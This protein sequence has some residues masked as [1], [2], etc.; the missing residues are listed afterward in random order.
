M[1]AL[2]VTAGDSVI[3]RCS[4]KERFLPTPSSDFPAV[5]Y[6]NDVFIGKEPTG[7][8]TLG[9]VSESDTGLYRCEHP[10]QG[11]SPASW[12]TVRGN[13]MNLMQTT[14]EVLHVSCLTLVVSITAGPPT[15]S[16]PP[17]I[18]IS[19]PRLVCTVLL[20]VLY[21]V[22]FILCVYVHCRRTKGKRGSQDLP[23][24]ENILTLARNKSMMASCTRGP[25]SHYCGVD[26]CKREV[27]KSNK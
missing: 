3:L 25:R 13:V 18:V 17:E 15:V 12:L 14:T 5:F 27:L 26:R 4:Y 9:D 24:N 23:N 1:P 7:N 11:K 8:M 19:L 20:V 16:P 6:K 22:T 21:C 2:P 10:K